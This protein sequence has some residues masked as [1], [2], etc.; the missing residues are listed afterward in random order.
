ML[1]LLVIL[2]GIMFVVRLFVCWI[3][4]CLSTPR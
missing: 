1:R 4:G 2:L 3:A